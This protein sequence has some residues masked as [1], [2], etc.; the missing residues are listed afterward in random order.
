MQK[1]LGKNITLVNTIA[2][3]VVILVGAG[4]IFLAKDILH[5]VYKSKEISGD[6]MIVDS[7][8]SD[9]FQFLL[10]MHHFLI[11]PD[12]AYAEKAME[13]LAKMEKDVN[14]Y[15]AH[16]E[17][18][19]YKERLLELE[20]LNKI[21]SDIKEQKD[22]FKLFKEYSETGAFDKDTFQGLEEFGYAIEYNIAE[23]NRIHFT[24]IKQ[25]EEESLEKMWIILV[26]Y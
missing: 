7:I 18:E 16:E 20:L 6:I 2:F 11:D 4:S 14:N 5:N 9:S 19:K 22:I 8:H 25:W 12:E 3:I 24:K 1:Q 10:A 23:I 17:A 15:I 21:Q 26:L 13:L